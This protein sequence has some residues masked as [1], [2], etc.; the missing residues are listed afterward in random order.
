[1]SKVDG[2]NELLAKLSKLENASDHMG[3]ACLAGALVLES[4]IK[5]SMQKSHGGRR[6]KRGGKQ[7]VAS[8]PGQAPA[9]DYGFLINSIQS[10]QEQNGASVWTNAEY[11][12]PLEFGTARMGARPFM[13]PGLDNNVAEI[14]KAVEVTARRLIEEAAA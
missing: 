10:T 14:L 3:K 8:A 13:R 12:P 11:A 5:I 9:I 2:V 4:R 7:H 1:M 6:Y